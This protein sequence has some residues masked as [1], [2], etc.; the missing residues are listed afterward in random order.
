VLD[1]ARGRTRSAE[2]AIQNLYRRVV[3]IK[4][5]GIPASRGNIADHKYH[6]DEAQKIVNYRTQ[7]I[8]T[9]ESGIARLKNEV[10]ELI[11]EEI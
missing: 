6:R 7:S 4:E 1:A 2:D 9:E 8:D 3:W 11:G 10:K 5:V